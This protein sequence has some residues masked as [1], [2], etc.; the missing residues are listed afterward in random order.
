MGRTA[1]SWGSYDPSPPPVLFGSRPAD[2]HPPLPPPPP[3]PGPAGTR[4][5]L[6]NFQWPPPRARGRVHIRVHQAFLCHCL[7]QRELR[8]DKTN[9]GPGIFP[10]LPFPRLNS[11]AGGHRVLPPASGSLSTCSEGLPLAVGLI[12][13]QLHGA[14]P[15]N[16]WFVTAQVRRQPL[17]T[18]EAQKVINGLN[19]HAGLWAPILCCFSHQTCV[20]LG[21]QE[22]ISTL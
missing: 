20:F 12:S 18:A 2:A 7:C 16:R 11:Y 4:D 8:E 14:A 1:G 10:S 22:I 5:H 9:P 3:P 6:G 13:L 21:I 15:H 19:R 17:P